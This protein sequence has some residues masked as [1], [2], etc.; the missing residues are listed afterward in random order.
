MLATLVVHL[1]SV[2]RRLAEDEGGFAMVARH[3]HEGGGFLYGP[4]WVDRPPGLI[5][6]F[7]AAEHLGPYGV[8]LGATLLAVTL[9]AAL[10]WAADAVGGRPAAKWAAWAGFA[11]ASSV[12]LHAQS[13]NGELAAATFVTLSVGA[14]LRAVRVSGRTRT[15]LLGASAGAA[16]T[17]AVLMKQNFVDAFVF[18]T[19]LL[20]VGVATRHNRLTYRPGQVLLTVAGFVAGALVPAGWTVA[21][22]RGHGGVSTLLY[23][24]VGFRADASSVM[25]HWSLRAPLHRFGTLML[26]AGLSGLLLLG[27]HL[28]FCHRHRLR[29]LDPL[30]WAVAATAGVELVGVLAGGNF[31]SHYLIALIPMVALAAGL[32]VNKRAPG[33]RWTRRLVVLAALVT[34]VVSP[35]AAVQAAH[36]T[37]QAYTTGRWVAAAARSADTIVV[38]F[39]HATVINASGLRPGYPYAW[40]LPVR[41]LDPRLTLLTRTL[42]RPSAPTWV[43]RWDQPHAWGLDPGNHVD[44][45]LRT[46]YRAVADVCGH[47]VWLHDGIHRHLAPTPPASAC[48]SGEQ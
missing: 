47:T 46:H 15:A 16:A 30:P 7:A 31:W 9:V 33:A 13:L 41:T 43:V 10:A 36:R 17:V 40:S 12:L 2:T 38:P 5:T 45:A 27:A 48:G 42:D 3:W 4:Q 14:L 28:A 24:L 22:A 29:H 20:A 26:L 37:S 21:W 25:A 11:F 18:A 8:R 23:A 44:T 35:V 19:V 32:S 39:T 6:L 34:G 1:L